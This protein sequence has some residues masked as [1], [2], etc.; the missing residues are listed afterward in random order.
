M[1]AVIQRVRSAKVEVDG[2]TI[3][4]IDRGLCI[5]LGIHQEDTTDQ[6]DWMV[7]K[8]SQLRI[9]E[10]EE[11]KMNRS[12]LD[13]GASALVV[14]QFTLYADCRKGRRPSFVGAAPPEKAIPL[15][16]DF[17]KRLELEGVPVQTG[18]FGAKMSVSIENDGPVTI[19]LD[20][21]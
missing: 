21:P 5:L 11:G 8:I 7:L 17:C 18:E 13:V 16:E 20:S 14:S 15:Y 19:V 1:R 2:K 12:L 6:V 4:E 9:F 10:D 3:G